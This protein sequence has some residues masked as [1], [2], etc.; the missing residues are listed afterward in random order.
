MPAFASTRRLVSN[1][2]WLTATIAFVALLLSTTDGRIAAQNAVR[3]AAVPKTSP[4]G[5][6]PTLSSIANA[7]RNQDYT[8]E[9]VRHFRDGNG[10]VVAVRERLEVAANG[11]TA[12]DFSLTFLGVVGQPAGSPLSAEWQRNYSRYARLFFRHGSFSVRDL[13]KASSNYV[14]HDFGP[15]TR[16]GRQARRFVVFPATLDKAIWLLDVDCATS[17]PLFVAEF[18]SQV[19]VQS[20]ID[21]VS[22]VPSVAQLAPMPAPSTQVTS[23]AD[24]AAA[25]SLIGA[26]VP[27]VEPPLGLLPDYEVESV[28]VHDDPINARQ[29]LVM[30]YGDGIDRFLVV[31]NVNTLDPFSGMPS[32]ANGGNTIARFRDP[33]VSALVFWDD[34]VTFHVAGRGSLRRLDGL[35]ERLFVQAL[36][37]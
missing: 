18:D 22:F 21:P 4:L 16:I 29:K 6:V 15:V 5:G 10:G 8:A 2:H 1:S 14:L 13:V 37:Q 28:E 35:A 34:G 23:V 11:S 36:S 26:G 32:E 9:Q 27:I 33:A 30:T 17:V 3:T 24:F 19:K 31:Q 20:Q 25:Q 7:V 12:P